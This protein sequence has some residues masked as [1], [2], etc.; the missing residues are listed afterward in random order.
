MSLSDNSNKHRA[1]LVPIKSSDVHAMN[2]SKKGRDLQQHL[3]NANEM[4]HSHFNTGT[5]KYTTHSREDGQF[6]LKRAV[7]F[8]PDDTELSTHSSVHNTL[9]TLT[10]T[11]TNTSASGGMLSLLK[12]ANMANINTRP[13]TAS[14]VY[15]GN[16]S[17]NTNSI[18][19]SS[20]TYSADPRSPA[21]SS[22]SRPYSPS[23]KRTE[24]GSSKSQT[25][26]TT[27]DS[28]EDNFNSNMTLST[29]MVKDKTGNSSRSSFFSNSVVVGDERINKALAQ[30]S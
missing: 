11:N 13:N 25:L 17:T 6:K 3:Q 8:V 30:V 27:S 2:N 23:H 9:T 22:K 7:S 29:R 10:N 26:H 19:P 24:G 20:N 28:E 12:P 5:A 15:S 18:T 16:T 4:Q 14:S 1:E 21:P